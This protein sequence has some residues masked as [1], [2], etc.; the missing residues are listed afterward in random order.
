MSSLTQ[1]RRTVSRRLAG[2]AIPEAF[3]SATLA[4]AINAH[5]RNTKAA[6]ASRARLLGKVERLEAIPRY[7]IDGEC[8]C[9]LAEFLGANEDSPIDDADR[10]AIAALAIG[11]S[12]TLGG[13]ASAEYTIRRV[14]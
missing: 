4:S 12:V 10:D 7:D 9:T 11:E 13:G 8:V 2:L 3:S 1:T 5:G 14:S 6:R